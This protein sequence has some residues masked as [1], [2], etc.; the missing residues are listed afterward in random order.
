MFHHTRAIVD[1]PWRLQCGGIFQWA[2]QD[3]RVRTMDMRVCGIAWKGPVLAWQAP[4]DMWTGVSQGSS[5][6]LSPAPFY[7]RKWQISSE[8][9]GP[10]KLFALS[11]SWS[12]NQCRPLEGKPSL[13]ILLRASPGPV[14]MMHR[15]PKS[16]FIRKG[17]PFEL[18][19]LCNQFLGQNPRA[20]CNKL[21]WLSTK[22]VYWLI[23]VGEFLKALSNVLEC[24]EKS[25]LLR[26][27]EIEIWYESFSMHL[28]EWNRNKSYIRDAFN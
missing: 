22:Q 23:T 2:E 19:R 13:R 21:L 11:Q 10:I 26:F 28:T 12:P 18:Q 15:S 5:H 25:S 17:A 14:P 7:V 1:L 8:R 24:G 27:I 16:P 3:F 6:S 4:G 9:L 20:N